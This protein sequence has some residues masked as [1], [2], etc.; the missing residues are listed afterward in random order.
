MFCLFYF[1][2]LYRQSNPSWS[3]DLSG[4]GSI[5]AL[6]PSVSRETAGDSIRVHKWNGTHYS[7]FFNGLPAGETSAVSLSRDGKSLAVGLPYR[8]KQ[9]GVTNV[10]KFRPLSKCGEKFQLLRLSLTTDGNPG[11]TRWDLEVGSNEKIQSQS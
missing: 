11:E 10:Y 2:L 6:G 7:A 4:D 9:G 3:V 5:L 1:F 8:G